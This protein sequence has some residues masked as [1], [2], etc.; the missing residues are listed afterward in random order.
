M[1]VLQGIMLVYDVTNERSFYNI[2]SW[3]GEVEENVSNGINIVI[4]SY[5]C[6]V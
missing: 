1:Y 6:T 5:I 4:D 2:R 3:M